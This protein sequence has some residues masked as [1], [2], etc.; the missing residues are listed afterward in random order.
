MNKYVKVT[1]YSPIIKNVKLIIYN[2]R[3][4]YEQKKICTTEW[5]WFRTNGHRELPLKYRYIWGKHDEDG[6]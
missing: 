3:I 5:Y 2:A 4:S 6:F 1:G